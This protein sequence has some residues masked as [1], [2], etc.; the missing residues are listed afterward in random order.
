MELCKSSKNV[1]GFCPE[2]HS[3]LV[4]SWSKASR[5]T[6]HK[7]GFSQLA[8][9]ASLSFQALTGLFSLAAEEDDN[10]AFFDFFF[11]CGVFRTTLLSKV[12]KS[13]THKVK[14]HRPPNVHCSTIYKSR[15][16]EAT[17]CPLTDEWI[18]KR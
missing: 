17:E 6:W 15:D 16:M 2:R 14:R 3:W 1:V 9:E 11:N 8:A 13:V 12:K 18:K 4:C 5:G 7:A 10:S